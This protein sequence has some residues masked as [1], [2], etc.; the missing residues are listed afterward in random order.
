MINDNKDSLDAIFLVTSSSAHVTQAITALENGYHVFLEKPM[1]ITVKECKK[2][3]AI[4]KKHKTQ[5]FSLGFV[6]RFDPS[7]VY[8]KE[9]I[10][11]GTIGNPFMIRAHT[12][13][14]DRYAEFQLQF[15]QSAGGIFLDYNVHDI[16]LTRWL[17]NTEVHSVY[18]RGGSYVHKEFSDIGDADNTVVLAT[19]EN[20]KIAVISASRTAFHGHDTHT[21]IIGSKGILKI[22]CEPSKN[23]VEIFD[24]HGIRKECVK[25]FFSRFETAFLH[26]VQ[27][28]IQC[29]LDKQKP[30]ITA[31]DGTKATEVSLAML[32]S[33]KEGL[34]LFASGTQ[35]EGTGKV[36]KIGA[37]MS[38]FSDKWQ[39]YLQD[40]VRR[41]DKER[42]DVEISMT[43]GKDDPATQLN[44]I[45][46]LLAQ[47]TDA[48]IIVPVD[49]SAMGP[50]IKLTKE[51]KVP[52]VVIN[53]LPKDEFLKDIDVYVGSD[54]IE[55]GIMQAK[56][57]VDQH[58]PK[59]K[60]GIIMGPL[61]HEA[62]TM[63]TKG[64]EQVFAQNGIKVVIKAEG[65]WDRAKGQQI[66]ENWF[67]SGKDLDII[68]SNNDEMAI[69]A[70]LAARS[71]GIKDKDILIVGLDAT[72]DAI[73][74]LGKGL[75]ATVFQSA[76]GQGYGAANAAYKLLMGEKLEKMYWIPYELVTP[77][78]KDQYQ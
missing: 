57:I 38:S 69:G 8:A 67:Q 39:T 25:D 15:V 37:A 48:I 44:Q 21:E 22:G 17:L 32:Q 31:Y 7:Y 26:E 10:D 35:E 30:Q 58:S 65:K 14:F 73:E 28:F 40:G 55:G 54:S 63:R 51:A 68:V 50:I 23:H 5:L 19:L 71:M 18:A 11:Q 2:L 20:N 74:Y 59:G 36:Y 3:E 60:A 52:L 6:R 47:G 29:I 70:V 76:D 72:P 13:D 9:L 62:A 33:F 78:N 61:G 64:N 12:A 24:H 34:N 41:F 16:D 77:E 42:D 75:D 1:G 45:E 43:D 66:A 53:R 56:W 49:I 46:T 4:V 27:N